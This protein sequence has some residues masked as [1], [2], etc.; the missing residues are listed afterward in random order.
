VPP[1]PHPF[2]TTTPIISISTAHTERIALAFQAFLRRN[3]MGRTSSGILNPA[4]MALITDD[5]SVTEYAADDPGLTVA[6]AAVK[7][8]GAPPDEEAESISN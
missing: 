4:A 3:A 6:V 8:G 2:M 5:G 1:P 7:F